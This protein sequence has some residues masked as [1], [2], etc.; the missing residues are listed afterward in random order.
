M[1]F[2]EKLKKEGFKNIWFDKTEI[3]PGDELSKKWSKVF[4]IL[5]FLSHSFQITIFGQR[6]V[7]KIFF[8][9]RKKTKNVFIW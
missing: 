6:I 2:V 4:V 7:E 5:P 8:M 9:L 1:K 3:H